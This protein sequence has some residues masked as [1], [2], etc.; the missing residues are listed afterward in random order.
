M[1]TKAATIRQSPRVSGAEEVSW[2]I[3]QTK[4]VL[5][6]KYWSI[7]YTLFIIKVPF[8][9][10]QVFPFNIELWLI[11]T[12]CNLFHLNSKI[13]LL[14]EAP[15]SE[16]RWNH[17]SNVEL[18]QGRL[19]EAGGPNISVQGQ[20]LI[21]SCSTSVLVSAV[22]APVCV[23]LCCWH[24]LWAEWVRYRWWSNPAGHPLFPLA[25]QRDSTAKLI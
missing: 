8:N 21:I 18:R 12:L 5:S 24:G 7:W 6:V 2:N 22:Q 13:T 1:K 17:L 19:S 25:R 23:P 10:I 4:L 3:K 15:E 16:S 11:F 14:W 20:T 9:F